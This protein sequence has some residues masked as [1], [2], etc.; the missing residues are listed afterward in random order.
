MLF[1]VSGKSLTKVLAIFT[2][3]DK[4]SIPSDFNVS[5]AQSP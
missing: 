1:S 3:E 5:I 2:T 4:D